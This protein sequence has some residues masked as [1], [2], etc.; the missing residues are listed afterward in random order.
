MSTTCGP[1]LQPG[2]TCIYIVSFKP[3]APGLRTATISVSTDNGGNVGTNMEGIGLPPI[4]IQPCGYSGSAGEP[5]TTKADAACVAALASTS[6]GNLN[7]NDSYGLDF[8]QVSLGANCDPTNV[9][10]Y[11]RDGQ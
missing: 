4:S 9:K 2:Q 1:S 7:K 10:W 5:P 8:G 11:P 6:G 3:S